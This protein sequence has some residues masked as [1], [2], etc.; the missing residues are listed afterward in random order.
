[1]CAKSRHYG[2]LRAV[3]TCGFHCQ[4]ALSRLPCG[5]IYRGHDISTSVC[6]VCL[7][8]EALSLRARQGSGFPKTY[9][10]TT[11]RGIISLRCA[12]IIATPASLLPFPSVGLGHSDQ[13]GACIIKCGTALLR[14]CLPSS[15]TYG[16]MTGWRG[17][18]RLQ[19]ITRPC[20]FAC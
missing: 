1:M 16:G 2:Q 18:C 4:W 12:R 7:R 9:D 15:G 6:L 5:Q 8:E 14:L 11:G 3:L 20:P 13:G 19:I 17:R 10:G